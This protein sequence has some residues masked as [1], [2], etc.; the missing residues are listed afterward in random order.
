MIID[1]SE[2]VWPRHGEGAYELRRSEEMQD[3]YIVKRRGVGTVD[4]YNPAMIG[5]LFLIFAKTPPTD[6]GVLS[7][8]G[9]FGFLGISGLHNEALH[10]WQDEGVAWAESLSV[11]RMYIADVQEVWESVEQLPTT[12]PEEQADRRFRI[13]QTI[14]NGLSDIQPHF[15][16][17]DDGGFEWYLA[18][19][20]LIGLIWLQ[21]ANAISTKANWRSCKYCGEPF[22]A[23]RPRAI[24]CSEGHRQLAYLRRKAQRDG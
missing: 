9:R 16:T 21:L 19:G 8:A 6:E 11:W 1:Q 14:Q 7:F 4:P 12:P 17:A 2:F 3:D 18:P 20:T 13:Q 15:R 10:P 22:E 24:Y 23:K 5:E